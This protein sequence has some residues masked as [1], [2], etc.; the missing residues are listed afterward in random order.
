[1][2]FSLL[3]KRGLKSGFSENLRRLKSP[4]NTQSSLTYSHSAFLGNL[5]ASQTC[6]RSFSIQ[7]P[8]F[9]QEKRNSGKDTNEDNDSYALY[10]KIFGAGITLSAIYFISPPSWKK[11]ITFT[12]KAPKVDDVSKQQDSEKP[13]IAATEPTPKENKVEEDNILQPTSND[14]K[15]KLSEGLVEENEEL[16][17]ETKHEGAYNPETGEIN[18]DCPCLGGMADG[19]CG[20]EFK[21]AFSCFVYSEAD[22]KGIDCVEKFQ[23]MQDCFRKYPEHYSDVLYD[24]NDEKLEEQI[25]AKNAILENEAANQEGSAEISNDVDEILSDIDLA[26]DSFV[27]VEDILSDSD[28]KN[29]EET[30]QE[31]HDK[32]N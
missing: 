23:H 25:A 2:S 3:T 7:T 15:V 9:E 6:Q 19:P 13:N 29:S 4:L 26:S 20:E 24:E 8:Q 1:M 18:W 5:R 12:K 14:G 31:V 30:T 17:A 10:G 32:N 27:E 21:E 28:N 22:P 16:L 11:K